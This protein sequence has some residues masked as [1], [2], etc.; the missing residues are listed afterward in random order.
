MGRGRII[1]YLTPSFLMNM[2]EVYAKKAS[3]IYCNSKQKWKIVRTKLSELF[4]KLNFFRII[5]WLFSKDCLAN[6]PILF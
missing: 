1:G 5:D 4:I 3:Y 6:W 2:K